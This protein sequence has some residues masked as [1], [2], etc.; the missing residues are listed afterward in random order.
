M[1]LR[2]Q[3]HGDVLLISVQDSRIDAARAIQFKDGMRELTTAT[4]GRVVLDLATVD[5]IDSSGLGAVVAAMKQLP[6]TQKLELAAL[7]PTVEK[8]F[9]LTRMD[10]VFVIHN[11]AAT[12]LE[13][14]RNTG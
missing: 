10:Q 9:R 6:A 5:F 2:S 7:S 8:V 13:Q 11:D 3:R 4:E 1:N 14:H 12:A